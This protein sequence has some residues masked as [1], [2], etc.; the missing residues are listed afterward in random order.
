[1][2]DS[3][4]ETLFDGS[5]LSI[6]YIDCSG[7]SCFSRCPAKFFFERLLGLRPVGSA[8]KVNIAPDYGTCIHRALPYAYTSVDRAVEEFKLA[9]SSYHYEELHDERRNI[10]RATDMLANFH[11]LRSSNCPYEIIQFP[12]IAYE[13]AERISPNEVPFL[14]DVGAVYPFTGRIDC[15]IK[16]KSSGHVMALDYKTAS[17]ISARLFDCFNLSPQAIGYTIALGMLTGED[18]FGLAIEA[19]RVSPTNDEIQIGLI[20]VSER[21]MI[22]FVEQLTDASEQMAECLSTNGWPQRFANCSP[23][24]THGQPGRLCPYSHL[25]DAANWHDALPNYSRSQPFD[26]FVLSTKETDNG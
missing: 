24:A 11:R 7:F 26:P 13:A 15:P 8:E 16:L 21:A 22:C 17:E 18:V 23:Y 1:M 4:N 5:P 10:R 6:K 9:W 12:G 2:I 3:T 19:L 14:V 25:C 20:P